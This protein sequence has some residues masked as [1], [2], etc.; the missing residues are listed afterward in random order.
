MT[1][2]DDN[3]TLALLVVLLA[4]TW[5]T[6]ERDSQRFAASALDLSSATTPGQWQPERLAT[7]VKSVG[8]D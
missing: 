2:R 1:M 4:A 6:I 5:L 8:P 3:M 7:P